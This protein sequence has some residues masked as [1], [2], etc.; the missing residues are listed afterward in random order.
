[1]TSRTIKRLLIKI[2]P[3]FL[4]TMI[5]W[6]YA[7]LSRLYHGVL[8]MSFDGLLPLLD[9]TAMIKRVT[10]EGDELLL[11]I[12]FQGRKIGLAVTAPDITSNS[13]LLLALFLSSPIKPNPRLYAGFFAGS[14]VVLFG[15]HLITVATN[16][17][18]AF[19]ANPEIA[20]GLAHGKLLTGMMVHYRQFYLEYG[21]YLFVLA[22]WCPYLIM[23]ISRYR[24][25]AVHGE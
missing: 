16:V 18:F 1:M 10:L 15:I 24:S 4:V 8:A 3:V 23:V 7:G 9:P 25:A 11:R 22:L 19:M 2:V 14:V 13:V 21:M 12:L 20:P 6:H 17:Q 5:L